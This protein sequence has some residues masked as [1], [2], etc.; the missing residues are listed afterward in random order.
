MAGGIF[1][2]RPFE[3][4]VKCILFSL[5]CMGLFLARPT[6]GTYATATALVSIFVVAYVGMAW[7]D[8]Y[9]NCD[10]V[11][12]RKGRLG[13]LTGSLKPPA[14]APE[15]QYGGPETRSRRMLVY[16]FH[17][18]LVVPILGYLVYAISRGLPIPSGL[19]W[20]IGALTVFTAGYHGVYLAAAAQ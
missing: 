20:L 12:L 15:Q 8:Y 2:Q 16:A 13:G 6:L 7:Y 4:N 10:V 17:L 3:L 14:H 18:L 19:L 1:T 5:L 9:F 11:P